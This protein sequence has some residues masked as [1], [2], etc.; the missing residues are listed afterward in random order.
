M[1]A[2]SSSNISGLFLLLFV[3][4]SCFFIAQHSLAKTR[5]ITIVRALYYVARIR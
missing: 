2:S 3:L 1:I 5:L 4:F